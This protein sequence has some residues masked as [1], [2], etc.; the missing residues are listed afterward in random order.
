MAMV[1]LLLL[2]LLPFALAGP[3]WQVCSNGSKYAP[4]SAY[5]ENLTLL[6][7]TL[8]KKAASNATLFATD[9]VGVAPDT[10]FAVT[11]CRGDINASACEGCVSS[12]FQEGQQLCPY[13]KDATIYY[14]TC[15]LT[16][17]NKNFVDTN[18]GGPNWNIQ[19]SVLKFTA[20]ANSTRQMVSTLINSTAQSAANSS[21]RF[22]T[23]RLD[24]SSF[25]TMYCL[26]QCRPNLTAGDC[27]S[28]FRSASQMMLQ[29][30]DR[31]V[32]CR[33]QGTWCSMRYEAN[34]FFQ[35]DPML[36][37]AASA[38]PPEVEKNVQQHSM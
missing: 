17:S 7:S 22:W 31:R 4:N 15:M 1:I 38:A 12:A 24:D 8:P 21:R 36:L 2:L 23:S 3:P 5:L 20:S 34:K 27:A 29:D 37:I 19:R 6:S 28:C 30:L 11:L 9:A 26:T 35:G 14:D 10:V 33:V 25:P 16:F 18:V 32:G 13:S